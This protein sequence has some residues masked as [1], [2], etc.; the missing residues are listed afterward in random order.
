MSPQLSS[1][2]FM[3][4]DNQKRLVCGNINHKSICYHL[5]YTHLVNILSHRRLQICYRQK[6]T[7]INELT[8]WLL[9]KIDFFHSYSFI[10]PD[11]T[12]VFLGCKVVVKPL[13]YLQ[14]LIFVSSSSFFNYFCLTHFCNQYK[15]DIFTIS[16]CHCDQ[17]I[18]K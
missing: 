13:L 16:R 18:S 14:Y 7:N 2:Y 4:V 6:L 17:F 9:N 1:S 15:F 3:P 5:H 11:F 12:C 10:E 8:K